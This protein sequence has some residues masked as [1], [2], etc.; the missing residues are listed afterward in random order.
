MAKRVPW[1]RI[2]TVRFQNQAPS[3][4]IH[5]SW[6]IRDSMTEAVI[7]RPRIIS[8]NGPRFLAWNFM[9]FIRITA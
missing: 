2:S 3:P 5:C 8:D 6:E 7:E 1:W 4:S 9:E